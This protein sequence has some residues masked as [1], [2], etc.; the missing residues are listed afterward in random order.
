[1]QDILVQHVGFVVHIGLVLMVA[2]MTND[3][4]EEALTRRIVFIVLM[5]QL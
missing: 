3:D 5:L 4:I 1:M 2:A